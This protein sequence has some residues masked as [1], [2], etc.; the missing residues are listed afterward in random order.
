MA[1]AMLR[2][3]APQFRRNL[4][5]V[6]IL[7]TYLVL[8]TVTTTIFQTFD[9]ESVDDPR[10]P[11]KKSY[12]RANHAQRCE[13]TN[14]VL[15]RVFAVLSCFMWPVGVPCLYLL[16][17]WEKRHL[18]DPLLPDGT[19]ARMSDSN[20]GPARCAEA[21]DIRDGTLEISHLQLLYGPY[22]PQFY[23]WEIFELLRRVFATSLLLA[24]RNQDVK[25]FYS[26][27]LALFVIKVYSYC[28]PFIA[29]SDDVLAET[30]NWITARG[31][32]PFFV[33]PPPHPPKTL[34]SH[35]PSSSSGRSRRRSRRS[36]T[37]SAPPS[38]P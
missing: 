9:C 18:L 24:F 21:L 1:A 19:K 7:V 28:E 34:V 20:D 30:I 23:L 14:Y 8:P 3:E 37:A 27:F 5:S 22:E 15:T 17:L 35:R 11:G 13:G 6:T 12:L 38:S 36:S 10:G 26:I 2:S 4:I 33:V 32:R 31:R 29:D 16:T 25:I